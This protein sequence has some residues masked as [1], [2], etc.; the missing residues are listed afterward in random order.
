MRRS[1]AEIGILRRRLRRINGFADAAAVSNQT[2]RKT[3]PSVPNCIALPELHG[4]RLGDFLPVQ[5][6]SETRIQI[7]QKPLSAFKAKLGVSARNHRILLRFKSDLTFAR[8]AP[9]ADVF[10]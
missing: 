3:G 4:L 8:V 7:V 10:C 9:D 6:S 1:G 2:T 5:G